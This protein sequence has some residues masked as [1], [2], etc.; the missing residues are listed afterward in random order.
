[1]PP[2]TPAQA[3][4]IT[5]DTSATKPGAIE[6]SLW[7]AAPRRNCWRAYMASVAAPLVTDYV[8]Q[9]KPTALAMA[10]LPAYQLFAEAA[11]QG[12]A[13]DLVFLGA[14]WVAAKEAGAIVPLDECIRS[15]AELRNIRPEL[16]RLTTLDGHIWAVPME[17]SFRPL[18]FNKTLLRQIGWSQT[19]VDA[20][21][22]DIRTGK[23]TLNDLRATAMETIRQGVVEPGFGFWPDPEKGLALLAFYRADGGQVYDADTK[24]LLLQRDALLNTFRFY[25]MLFAENVTPEFYKGDRGPQWNRRIVLR[26]TVTAGRVLFWMEGTTEWGVYATD[27][28]ADRGGQAYLFETYG[29]ALVPAARLNGSPST[30][31]AGVRFYAIASTRATG[32]R[33]N[34]DAACALLAKMMTPEVNDLHTALNAGASVLTTRPTVTAESPARYGYDTA[35]MLDYAWDAWHPQFGTYAG[36]ITEFAERLESS[37]ATPEQLVEQTIERMRV[38]FGDELIVE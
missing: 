33:N 17:M 16:W 28:L 2:A 18:F 13:P 6:V 25:R 22:D 15:Y 32:R 21:A 26:D 24:R 7:A 14:E 4:G 3:C 23:F 11:R 34:Q 29:Y 37:E 31:F 9:A 27:K 10:A 30:L 36:I 38:T 5:E 20:L 8:I 19:R 35:Y 1:M 12:R